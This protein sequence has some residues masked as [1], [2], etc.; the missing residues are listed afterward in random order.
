MSVCC[1]GYFQ[2][3]YIHTGEEHFIIEP[4]PEDV[5][6]VKPITDII[7]NS[8]MN[9]HYNHLNNITPM[10]KQ[11]HLFNTELYDSYGN[12]TMSVSTSYSTIMRDNNQSF[13]SSTSRLSHQIPSKL[14]SRYSANGNENE[15]NNHQYPQYHSQE[16][17]N[18]EE[19]SNLLKGMH[20][21]IYK[22]EWHPQSYGVNRNAAQRGHHSCG[23]DQ[24][25]V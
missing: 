11:S 5:M 24:G 21:I 12:N 6:L 25:N 2:M 19:I 20:H 4:L 22:H 14:H 16:N 3:G 9:N 13:T 7:G 15:N 8:N 18:E 23:H 17:S 10:S 1:L